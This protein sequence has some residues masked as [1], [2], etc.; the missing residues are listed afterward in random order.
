MA[1]LAGTMVSVPVMLYYDAVPV[2]IC[3]AWAAVDARRT[4]WLPWE[5]ALYLAA[6]AISFQSGLTRDWVPVPLTLPVS[7][8]LLVFAVKRARMVDIAPPGRGLSAAQDRRPSSCPMI[9]R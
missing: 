1:L 9:P 5:K 2:A 3:L 4:G 8:G 7:L 6:F